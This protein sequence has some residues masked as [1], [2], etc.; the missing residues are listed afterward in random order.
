MSIDIRLPNITGQTEREQLAQIKSYLYQTAQQ[1]QWALSNLDPATGGVVVTTQTGKTGSSEA[2]G[3]TGQSPTAS[4]NAIKSL[5]I[6][7]ADIVDAYYQEIN[8]RLSG[9]YVAESD[10]GTFAEQTDQDIME[11]STEIERAFTNIQQIITDIT[12]L[13]YNLIE[14]TAHIRTGLLYTGEDGIPVYGIEVGQKNTVDGAEVF[15]KYARFTSDRLSFYDSNDVEVAYISDYKLHITNAE[16]AVLT[17]GAFQINT[18][19]GFRLKYVG[20]S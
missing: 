20:R 8:R 12:A 11:N 10:F 19:T 13:E 17:L 14:V 2:A 18:S 1:L 16:I 4:F 15:N 6:K 7:S 5:I 9:Q 3:D